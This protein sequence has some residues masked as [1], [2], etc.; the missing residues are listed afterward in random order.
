MFQAINVE[1]LDNSVFQRNSL[2][3]WMKVVSAF[4]GIMK[5]RSLY[6]QLTNAKARILDKLQF[7]SNRSV[8]VWHVLQ[9]ES[10][11]R[12]KLVSAL[13]L[14][15]KITGLCVITILDKRYNNLGWSSL[16]NW[17][18]YHRFCTLCSCIIIPYNLEWK[19][20]LLV[21][22]VLNVYLPAVTSCISTE[23]LVLVKVSPRGWLLS[24]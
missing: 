4:K 1:N 11:S 23:M 12:L 13:L 9:S 7:V 16:R 5:Y 20:L 3:Q 14:W 6:Y 21:A 24:F 8:S 2:A 18:A 10:W 17:L 15:L 19:W 22:S